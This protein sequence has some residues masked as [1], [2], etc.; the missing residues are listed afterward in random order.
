M[1]G[2]FVTWSITDEYVGADFEPRYEMPNA[3][4]N[5]DRF[6]PVDF[7]FDHVG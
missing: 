5:P 1:H 4:V 7:Q 2:S 6:N 3:A